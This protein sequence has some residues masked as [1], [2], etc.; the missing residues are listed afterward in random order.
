M[1]G[2]YIL[3]IDNRIIKDN[4]DVIYNTQSLI[5]MLYNNIDINN[6]SV[7][8]DNDIELYNKKHLDLLEEPLSFKNKEYNPNNWYFPEKYKN[9]DLKEYFLGNHPSAN[10]DRILLE[11]EEFNNHDANNI[12]R[13]AIY[14]SDLLKEHDEWVIGVGRGSSCACYLLYLLDINLVNPLDYDLD[15]KEF[16]K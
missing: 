12:L 8:I 13:W 5:E 10:K 14:F 16:L 4:G 1:L 3:K 9:L 11:I 15:I 2:R 6:T 7:D